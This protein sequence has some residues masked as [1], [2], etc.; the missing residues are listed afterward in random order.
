MHLILEAKKKIEKI[1]NQYPTALQLRD[2]M[3]LKQLRNDKELT[4]DIA[5]AV[6]ESNKSFSSSFKEIN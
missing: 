2:Q 5:L 6:R 3:L 4:Q 1:P